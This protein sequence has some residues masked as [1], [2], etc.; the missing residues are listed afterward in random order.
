MSTPCF[1]FNKDPGYIHRFEKICEHYN[2]DYSKSIKCVSTRHMIRSELK[3]KNWQSKRFAVDMSYL[4][5]LFGIKPMRW[6]T[7]NLMPSQFVRDLTNGLKVH[8]SSIPKCTSNVEF[9]K[10]KIR[11]KGD[12]KNSLKVS[13]ESV[14]SVINTVEKCIKNVE[15]NINRSKER[16]LENCNQRDEGEAVDRSKGRK[17]K[18]KEREKKEEK[19]KERRIQASNESNKNKLKNYKN[20]IVSVLK[21]DLLIFDGDEISNRKGF[22]KAAKRDSVIVEDKKDENVNKNKLDYKSILLDCP[23]KFNFN[24]AGTRVQ[25]NT[26]EAFK[27]TYEAVKTENYKEKNAIETS[28]KVSF[29]ETRVGEVN[30]S[31]SSLESGN[32]QVRDY[33]KEQRRALNMV[34][35]DLKSNKENVFEPQNEGWTAGSYLRHD[36]NSIV[37]KCS[38]FARLSKFEVL[39]DNLLEDVP[40]VLKGKVY[41][42]EATDLGGVGQLSKVDPYLN[43]RLKGEKLKI[44]KVK[45]K[46]SGQTKKTKNK[47]EKFENEVEK[48]KRKRS[49]VLSESGAEKSE[50]T[51]FQRFFNSV[52]S[53]KCLDKHDETTK[54]IFQYVKCNFI[55]NIEANF[56]QEELTFGET[57]SYL[58]YDQKDDNMG[59]DYNEWLD[60][61][62]GKKIRNFRGFK[63]IN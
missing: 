26:T 29:T 43:Y 52:R 41:K 5:V 11:D 35:S 59:F 28:R 21:D 8:R 15:D 3:L 39:R 17:E 36:V 50:I 7:N 47:K 57:I 27:N 13:G 56:T 54:P 9:D 6:L 53:L 32:R 1:V 30:K 55:K 49:V 46:K 4:G 31:L 51:D 38:S 12:C 10:E 42:E 33:M 24:I 19:K 60:M 20:N 48:R 14:L 44:E 40:G 63:I 62:V 58:K 61:Q 2:T 25:S 23:I 37:K 16:L 18:E 22:S 45:R 34:I